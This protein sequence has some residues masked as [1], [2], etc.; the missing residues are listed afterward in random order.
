MFD[1]ISLSRGLF[2]MLIIKKGGI[3]LHTLHNIELYQ[4]IYNFCLFLFI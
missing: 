3:F 2:M 4:F 1:P